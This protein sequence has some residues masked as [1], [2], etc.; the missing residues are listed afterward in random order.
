[1]SK[2][3]RDHAKE[4]CQPALEL[5]EHI[6]I[7]HDS[8]IIEEMHMLVKENKILKAQ[9]SNASQIVLTLSQS[10][11]VKQDS[12]YEIIKRAEDFIKDLTF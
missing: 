10:H 4:L 6:L 11:V 7:R 2:N 9:L 8:T 1:M 3:Y 5:I 12:D